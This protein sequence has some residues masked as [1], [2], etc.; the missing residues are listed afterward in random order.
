VRRKGAVERADVVIANADVAHV[1]DR[2][3]GGS[4]LAAKKGAAYRG[5]ELSSSAY[6][7]LA[8]AEKAPLELVHHNVFF[9]SDYKREFEELIDLRRPPADPTVYLC[10]DDRAP[11]ED[12]SNGERCFLLTN[13]PPLDDK[14]QRVDWKSE[15][16]RCK[17]RIVRTLARHGWKLEIREAMEQT[18]ADFAARFPGSKGALYGL[19]SNSKMAA[20]KRPPNKVEGIGGL[21]LVGGTVHPGAGLPMVCLSARMATQM[22]MEELHGR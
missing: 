21:F 10:A 14:G 17:E 3:L 12:P 20:F 8:V 16:P 7:L 19:S 9:S 2:L 22:A 5:E 18:P 15:A 6:V 13:A 1:Y 4:R 11:G